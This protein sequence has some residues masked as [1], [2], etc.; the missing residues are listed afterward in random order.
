MKHQ[1]MDVPLNDNAEQ[2]LDLKPIPKT[3]PY[4]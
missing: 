4:S 2:I 1:R 3:W